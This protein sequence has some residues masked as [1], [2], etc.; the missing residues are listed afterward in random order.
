MP[1]AGLP[2]THI[3]PLRAAAAILEWRA[4]TGADAD[5]AAK[6]A[7]LAQQA[8]DACVAENEY[9]VHFDCA[10]VTVHSP[11][12]LGDALDMWCRFVL[13]ANLRTC[14]NGLERFLTAYSGKRIAPMLD[15]VV[16]CAN[17]GVGQINCQRGAHV[18]MMFGIT[19]WGASPAEAARA[20]LDA[21]TATPVEVAA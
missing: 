18:V 6:V 12:S 5:A 3:S 19:G 17:I 20:W 11:T 15:L 1:K 8:F 13:L 7:Y 4:L 2:A 21:A 10:Q 16:Y 14:G 9:G